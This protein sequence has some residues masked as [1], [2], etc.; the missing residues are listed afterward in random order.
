MSKSRAKNQT[1]YAA[2][3]PKGP[4]CPTEAKK[5][6]HEAMAGKVGQQGTSRKPTKIGK[7]KATKRGSQ[8]IVDKIE[9]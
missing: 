9:Y 8:K 1:R 7:K 6:K 2:H 4:G 3:H 5:D